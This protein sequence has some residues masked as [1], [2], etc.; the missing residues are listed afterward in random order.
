M[1]FVFDSVCR[2]T[3]AWTHGEIEGPC[4]VATITSMRTGQRNRAAIIECAYELQYYLST[5]K[6][7]VVEHVH[8]M[9]P[10]SVSG[11]SQWS[12]EELESIV[13]FH[14]LVTGEIAVI[15]HTATA[16]YK[17]GELDLRR[18]KDS[19]VLYSAKSLAGHTPQLS[20]G[21]VNEMSF[22]LYGSLRG[23]QA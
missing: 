20:P 6:D 13:L 21:E 4:F 5:V 10:P 3:R 9:C 1:I 22:Q 15:Y 23:Q 11:R 7:V 12:L 8:M 18:K 2:E 16:T 17:M 19:R 14:G